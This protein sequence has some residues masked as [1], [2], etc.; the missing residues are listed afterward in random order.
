M[1]RKLQNG[2][3]LVVV[4]FILAVM[5]TMSSQMTQRFQVGL[6]RTANL[7]SYQQAI[8]YLLGAESFSQY[9]MYKQIESANVTHLQQLWAKEEHVFPMDGAT[10]RGRITDV[11]SRFNLNSL[12][13]PNPQKRRKNA[14]RFLRLLT[15]LDIENSE[16]QHIVEQTEQWLNPLPRG[17]AE[18]STTDESDV[19]YEAKDPPYRPAHRLMFDL[20]ELRAIDGVTQIIYQ[21]IKPFLCVY[22]E[23]TELIVNANTLSEQQ[24]EILAALFPTVGDLSV[25]SAKDILQSRSRQG[26]ATLDGFVS[27]L[28]QHIEDQLSDEDKKMFTVLSSSFEADMTINMHG[29]Q[30]RMRVFLKKDSDNNNMVV[31]R[32]IFGGSA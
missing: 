25:Q 23:N 31:R 1:V 9:F 10:L 5:V 24:P 6:K 18:D 16:A 4:L 29:N 2:V 20:S 7:I 32:R 28:G 17:N 22:P 8:S 21:R 12:G 14:E 13:N 15:L 26:W 11:H 19:I 3:A 30:L 27:A